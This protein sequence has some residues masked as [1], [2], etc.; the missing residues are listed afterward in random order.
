MLTQTSM[1]HKQINTP[2]N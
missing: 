1:N 2:Q